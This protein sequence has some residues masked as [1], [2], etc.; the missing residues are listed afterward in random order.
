MVEAMVELIRAPERGEEKWLGGARVAKARKCVRRCD[1]TEVGGCARRHQCETVTS[2]TSECLRCGRGR[3]IHNECAW[4]N[5]GVKVRIK[6]SV[7]SNGWGISGGQSGEEALRERQRCA[8]LSGMQTK[9]SKE[10]TATDR[11]PYP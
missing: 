11:F 7:L 3:W 6:T 8:R 1:S 4:P 5:F 10:Y 9:F 2:T